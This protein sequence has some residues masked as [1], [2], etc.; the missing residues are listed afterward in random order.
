MGLGAAPDVDYD[1]Y[2]EGEALLGWLNATV[3]VRSAAPFD[4]NAL[5]REL[6]AGMADAVGGYSGEVER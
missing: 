6:A 4:G 5:L 2:A 3:R 1:T